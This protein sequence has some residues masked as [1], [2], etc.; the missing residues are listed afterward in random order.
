MTSDTTASFCWTSTPIEAAVGTP[1]AWWAGS[2]AQGALR[3]AQ[4]RDEPGVD[5]GKPLSAALR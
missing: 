1:R 3:G 4:G 5:V 2:L